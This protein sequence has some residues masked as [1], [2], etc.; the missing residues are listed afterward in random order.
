MENYYVKYLQQLEKYCPDIMNILD[1][2]IYDRLDYP[3]H[4]EEDARQHAANLVEGWMEDLRRIKKVLN[5]GESLQNHSPMQAIISGLRY[6]TEKATLLAHDRY[7]DGN[8]HDRQGR[9]RYLYKTAKGR[10]FL[11]TTTRWQGERDSITP[12]PEEEALAWWED[13]PEKEVDYVEAFGAEP[14]EA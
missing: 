2:E 3:D 5:P 8:N 11:H 6:D 7:W 9:N 10:F 13:L 12:I 1:G 4:P 14:E